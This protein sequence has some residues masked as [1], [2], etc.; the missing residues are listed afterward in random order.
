M[1]KLKENLLPVK[2]FKAAEIVNH[3]CV[4]PTHKIVVLGQVRY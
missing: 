2:L 4:T 3:Y 1:Q